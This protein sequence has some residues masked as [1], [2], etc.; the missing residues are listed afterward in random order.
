MQTQVESASKPMTTE[1]RNAWFETLTP[2]EKRIRLA[3]D[4]LGQ[5]AAQKIQASHGHYGSFWFYGASKR[6]S[7]QEALVQRT[8]CSVCAKGALFVA[9]VAGYNNYN[10]GKEVGDGFTLSNQTTLRVLEGIFSKT[11]LNTIENAF[12]SYPHAA[13]DEDDEEVTALY[14][15][16]AQLLDTQLD[17]GDRLRL[18]ME[19]VVKNDGVFLIRGHY[20]TCRRTAKV[21]GEA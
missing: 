20:K 6:L 9:R 17:A 12:E 14:Q 19:N 18:I 4:V 8:R 2:R 15:A 7:Y 10:A 1:E 16:A 13:Y 11:Q 3:K 5:L 21:E